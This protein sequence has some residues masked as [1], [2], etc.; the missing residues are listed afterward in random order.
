ME[1]HSKPFRAG[2]AAI[3]GRPNV[4]KSTLLNA[5]LGFK[6]SIVSPKPQTTRHRILGILNGENFQICFLDTPGLIEKPINGLQRALT[7]AAKSAAREDADVLVF[8][9]EP[10]RP[11][12]E[13]LRALEVL[14]S[15]QVPV[16]LT[17]NKIDAA[18]PEKIAAARA[19]C[20][21]VVKPVASLGVSALKGTG[22]GELRDRLLALL[23]ES[24]PFYGTD[25]LS[26]R[27]ERFFAEEVIREKIF[28]LFQ[29]EIPHACAVRVEEFRERKGSPDQV[30][31]AIFV[32]KESQK[33]ILIGRQGRAIGALTEASRRALA[34][35]LGRR[36]E[37]E[38]RVGVR[39][40]W[41]K[42]P[43]ALKDFGYL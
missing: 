22:V 21:E 19:A 10:G 24:P 33:G 8:V 28:E 25:Q 12:E 3:V 14:A 2:F 7:V 34:D 40:G 6:L 18:S 38:L 20:E 27:W 36:V 31:A 42:D 4:G 9:A 11:R 30:R 15:R 23:P 41:R 32:E 43:K 39:A 16:V 26:D 29:Q 37:L 5:L 1:Y 13:E 17:V 35:F